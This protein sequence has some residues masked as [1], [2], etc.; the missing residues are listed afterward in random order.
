MKFA[1]GPCTELFDR[2]DRITQSSSAWV[3]SFGNSSLIS[4][5]HCPCFLKAKGDPFS[6]PPRRL[7][8][9]KPPVILAAS[10]A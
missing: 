6:L 10:F 7:P 3:A 9:S 8:P 5:P 1:A 4:M 2:I